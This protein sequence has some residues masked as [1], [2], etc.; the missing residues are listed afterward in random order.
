MSG[1]F[2]GME[3]TDMGSKGR[4]QLAC[5]EFPQEL[6]AEARWRLR[7]WWEKVLL[8]A[9]ALCPIDTGTLSTSGRIET[10]EGPTEGGALG[11]F[12]EKAVGFDNELINSMIVFGGLLVNPKTGRI[13]DYAQAVHDGHFTANGRFIPPQPFIEMAINIHIDEL[14]DILGKSIDRA[15]ETVW[16]GD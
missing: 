11:E 14:Y 7:F 6:T 16:T 4:A 8:T 10:R 1:G 13:C 12:Y 5:R 2:F 3:E 15:A 9:K